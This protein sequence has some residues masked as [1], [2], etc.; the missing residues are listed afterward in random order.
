MQAEPQKEHQWLEKMVGEWTWESPSAM[1]PGQEPKMYTGNES[2]RS[3]SGL[4]VVCEGRGGPSGGGTSTTIMSLGYDPR[5]KKYVGTF[6]GSMMAELWIYEG[7]LD[8]E[9]KVL[10][11]DSEGPSFAGDGKL[12]KYKDSIEF[13]SDDHRVLTS[14]YQDEEGNWHPFMEAHYYRK[15]SGESSNARG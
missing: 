6:I 8:A 11:L 13:K 3:L 4:W 9:G 15:S 10:T 1:E 2:V 7:E 14:T 12:A 5:K